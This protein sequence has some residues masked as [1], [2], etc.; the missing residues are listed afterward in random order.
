MIPVAMMM[1]GLSLNLRRWHTYRGVHL[2]YVSYYAANDVYMCVKACLCTY[3]VTTSEPQKASIL[4]TMCVLYARS[5]IHA[6]AHTR[7][8]LIC[9]VS[10]TQ[11]LPHVTR[12]GGRAFAE[13]TAVG[14][15]PTRH[16]AGARGE[17]ARCWQ[18]AKPAEFRRWV[19]GWSWRNHWRC[20]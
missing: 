12:A 10:R 3:N 9:S 16:G 17:G 20:S 14:S 1:T 15:R 4:H 11:P 5:T 18:A 19:F 2:L 13:C 8:T 6:S 7:C